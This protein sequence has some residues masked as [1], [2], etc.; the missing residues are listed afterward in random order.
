MPALLP[1]LQG[2][3]AF[4]TSR[5]GMICIAGVVGFGYGHHRAGVACDERQAAAV[6]AVEK[7]RAAE[8]ARQQKATQELA[9]EATARVEDAETSRRA[10]QDAIDAYTIKER[11]EPNAPR[12]S[13][14]PCVVDDDFLGVL[15]RLDA[16]AARSPRAPRRSR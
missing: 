12:P 2:L 9:A 5:I 13:S 14:G 11:S 10:M 8:L 3:W 4:A 15:R 6:A 7:A 1:I 16:A